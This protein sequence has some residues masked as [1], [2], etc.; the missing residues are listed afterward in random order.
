MDVFMILPL[1]LSL[2]PWALPL[3]THTHVHT[4]AREETQEFFSAGFLSAD[5]R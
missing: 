1:L 4:H 5:A 3:H 2:S